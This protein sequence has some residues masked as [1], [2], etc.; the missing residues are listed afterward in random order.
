M[1]LSATPTLGDIKSCRKSLKR[2]I[3]NQKRTL[4]AIVGRINRN[5][6]QSGLDVEIHSREKSLFSIF[7]KMK[8]RKLSFDQ[9]I[10]VYGLRV[11]VDQV[12]E[13]YQ[14]LGIV[15]PNL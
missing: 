7:N 9:V 5:L 12:E 1:R 6:K 13:C 2:K 11:I 10:D 8:N 15:A 3:G 14:V 4:G